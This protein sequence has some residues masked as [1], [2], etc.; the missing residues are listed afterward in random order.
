M[1]QESN[2]V[3]LKA[4]LNDKLEKEIVAFLNNHE[5]GVLYIGVD[6]AGNPIQL[7]DLDSLQLKIA[8]RIKNNILPSTLGLFDIV[9]DAIDGISVTKIIISSGL[10]KPYYVK[11]KG[12]SPNGCFMRI[13]TSTQPMPTTLIDELYSKR[14]HTTLRNIPAPRQDLTCAQL[15]IDYQERGLELNNRFAQSLELLTPDGQYNYIAYLLADENG[16][17]IKVAK[18][19]GTDKVDLI[20]NEEYGYCSLIKATNQVLEKMKVENV[21]KAKV[22]STK[23]IEKNLI[24]PV[25][26][27]EAL[28]NAIVHNDFS[29]E[30]PPVFEIF[31][32]RMEFTSYGGL[33]SGQSK[34]DFFSCSSMP[35]NRELMRVFKDVGLVEQLGSGMSRILKYYDRDIFEISD[36]FI[37]VVFP[38]SLSIRKRTDLIDKKNGLDCVVGYEGDIV[39]DIENGVRCENDIVND[40]E[41]GVRCENDIVNLSRNIKNIVNNKEKNE[42]IIL[43][44][45]EATPSITIRII[46]E[47]TGFSNSKVNRI[48]KKLKQEGKIER[49]GSDKKG[50]WIICK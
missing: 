21:T 5:G 18:Y 37:K 46:S 6:D 27:R 36:H 32:D 22:T 16:V 40:T 7:P 48:I 29:R 33:I 19:A 45:L 43:S 38:F 14:I 24:E 1:L 42:Q 35:R 39:N 28:I 4:N 47:N 34:E 8:D 15:N 44:I 3:E 2:R 23:R 26:L 13:G 30:I 31:S 12:M 49:R 9:T 20:E 41:N 25:P 10:E 50:Y 11:N 17:S